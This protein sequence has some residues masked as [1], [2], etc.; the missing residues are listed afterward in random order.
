M[1]SKNNSDSDKE[2]EGGGDH[3]PNT[4]ESH[5]GKTLNSQ[6]HQKLG[7][8][9]FAERIR[10]HHDSFQLKEV[11]LD[12]LLATSKDAEKLAKAKNQATPA[13]EGGIP[14]LFSE[15]ADPILHLIKKIMYA[16]GDLITLN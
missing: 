10:K 12:D 2:Q 11:D 7:R 8:L 14:N 16:E 5:Q 9:N 1:V 15:E 3:H 13:T 4:G 6:P